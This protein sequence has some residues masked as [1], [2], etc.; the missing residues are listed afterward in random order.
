M[1]GTAHLEVLDREITAL[2]H[3]RDSGAL[4]EAAIAV[5]SS[6]LGI[7]GA[8]DSGEAGETDEAL[9]EITGQLKS[10]LNRVISI[11]ECTCTE[12]RRVHE[13]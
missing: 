2:R 1:A 10:N 9:D 5:R 7:G 6:E 12:Y 8:S 3:L 4:K 11:L 13:E